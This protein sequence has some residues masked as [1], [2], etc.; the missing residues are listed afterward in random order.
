[1]VKRLLLYSVGQ[2]RMPDVME[3]LGAL[4]TPDGR[5]YMEAGSTFWV[6]D[7]AETG[8]VAVGEGAGIETT[9]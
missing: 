6:N 9:G 3:M 2:K 4:A 5:K 8:G 1:M 7:S